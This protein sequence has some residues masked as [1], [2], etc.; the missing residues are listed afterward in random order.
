MLARYAFLV[1]CLL[2][3]PASGLSFSAFASWFPWRHKGSSS[4]GLV[5][6]AIPVPSELAERPDLATSSPPEAA[7][8]AADPSTVVAKAPKLNLAEVDVDASASNN[9]SVEETAMVDAAGDAMFRRWVE[10]GPKQSQEVKDLFQNDTWVK[11]KL[12]TSCGHGNT[13]CAVVMVDKMIC[14]GL[15]VSGFQGLLGST[16]QL[17]GVLNATM[18]SSSAQFGVDTL[19]RKDL[20]KFTTDTHWPASSRDDGSA[21]ARLVTKM[22]SSKP[23]KA[24]V[25][26]TCDGIDEEVQDHCY[27]SAPRALFCQALTQTAAR[28]KDADELVPL[29]VEAAKLRGESEDIMSSVMYTGLMESTKEILNVSKEISFDNWLRSG[30]DSDRTLR[31]KCIMGHAMRQFVEKKCADPLGDCAMQVYDAMICG[32]LQ[33]LGD[34][35]AMPDIEKGILY[36]IGQAADNANTQFSYDITTRR[37]FTAKFKAQPNY[38]RGPEVDELKDNADYKLLQMKKKVMANSTFQKLVS[39]TCVPL[40]RIRPDCWVTAPTN[41]F[42]QALSAATTQLIGP[43]DLFKL[44]QSKKAMVPN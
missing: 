37:A 26:Q 3:A 44:M 36:V 17:Q 29:L 11:E 24:L 12:R 40:N 2:A 28:M 22:M 8:A 27:N 1:A 7:P 15:E 43:G 19:F 16:T 5:Q 41:L 33:R 34:A 32:A 42:C 6:Q 13:S 30:S 9:Q 21:F 38:T 14:E 39:R 10:T 31:A 4:S 35:V 20:Y 18:N 25:N 23:L